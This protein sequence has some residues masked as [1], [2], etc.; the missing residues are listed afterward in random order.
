MKYTTISALF[1]GICDAIR[2]K[3]GSS[4]AINH[5]DIP[6]RIEALATSGGSTGIELWEP[7]TICPITILD[8]AD[9]IIIEEEVA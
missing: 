8:E 1:T 6:A 7:Q 9:I 2:K 3:E 4:G 5:Q